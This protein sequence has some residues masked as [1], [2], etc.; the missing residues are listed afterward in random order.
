MLFSLLWFIDAFVNS[1]DMHDTQM[2]ELDKRHLL[3]K[4]TTSNGDLSDELRGAS[5]VFHHTVVVQC[6]LLPISY[7]MLIH[8]LL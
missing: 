8:H 5:A 4:R 2:S 7:F 1:T 6:L 3:D